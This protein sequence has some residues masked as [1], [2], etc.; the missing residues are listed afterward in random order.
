MKRKRY[1]NQAPNTTRCLVILVMLL[2]VA[3]IILDVLLFLYL[4]PKPGQVQQEND[5]T[6]AKV[7]EKNKGSISIPGYESIHLEAN[8][9]QQNVGLLN[10]ERNTCYFRI[11]LFLEDG[12]LLWQSDLV[13]PGKASEPILLERPLEAGFYPNAVIQY[14]CY[15][16][17]GKMT[18]LNGADTK[19]T[20]WVQ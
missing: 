11:S 13:E 10:P 14:D 18:A 8:T 6:E 17:D 20:L 7:V 16:M 12:T 3:L 5:V 19:L 2:L 9:K 1:Q 4:R 15:S